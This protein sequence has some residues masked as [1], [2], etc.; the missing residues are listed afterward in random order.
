MVLKA[1]H[2]GWTVREVAQ[3]VGIGGNAQLNRAVIGE[4]VRQV[5]VRLPRVDVGRHP[6]PQRGYR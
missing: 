3:H 1:G 5:E 2:A 4:H 6:D